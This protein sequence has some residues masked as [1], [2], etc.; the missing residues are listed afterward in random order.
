MEPLAP[1]FCVRPMVLEDLE[2]VLR[3]ERACYQPPWAP[4]IFERELSNAWSFVD[5]VVP[6]QEPGAPVGHLVYWVVHDELH[7]LNVAIAPSMRRRGLARA[8]LGRMLRICRQKRL[9][10]LALEVRVSNEG[11]IALYQSFGF[12]QIGRRKRYYADNGED[13]LVM[14]LVLTPEPEKGH[15]PGEGD[16]G[17]TPEEAL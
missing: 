2:A 3:V 7:I 4:A 6:E 17:G 16:R 12:K 15:P 5:L 9:Q 8:M 13:A 11:A 1:G 10:Y 14:A